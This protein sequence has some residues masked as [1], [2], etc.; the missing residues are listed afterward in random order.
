MDATQQG[1]PH[2]TRG[3]Y[4]VNEATGQKAQFEPPWV[5]RVQQILD[6]RVQLVTHTGYQ[7]WVDLDPERLR[8]ATRHEEDAYNASGATSSAL[9]ECRDVSTMTIRVSRDTGRSWTR[10]RTFRETGPPPATQA[11]PPCRCA[12]CPQERDR[13]GT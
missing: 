11:E 2:H 5:G 9:G 13:N 3:A 8:K 7:W 12:L 6:D 1:S 10:W 4:L